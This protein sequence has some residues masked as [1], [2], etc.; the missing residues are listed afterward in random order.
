MTRLAIPRKHRIRA[1]TV[2]SLRLEMANARK[3][4][5]RQTYG[6][7]SDIAR[8]EAASLNDVLKIESKTN[9]KY[10]SLRLAVLALRIYEEIDT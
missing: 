2:K 6:Y 10:R 3:H 9:L 4:F 8:Q 1:D 7:S 5:P